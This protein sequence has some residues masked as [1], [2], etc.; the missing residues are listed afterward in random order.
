M[1]FLEKVT[2]CL[3]SCDYTRARI[4]NEHY[5]LTTRLCT[6]TSAERNSYNFDG[7]LEYGGTRSSS[8][9]DAD[10]KLFSFSILGKRTIRLTDTILPLELQQY[11][12][13]VTFVT[14]TYMM[15]L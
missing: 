3:K 8:C 5:V 9:A 15:F 1:S 13:S 7:G 6:W 2:K 11:S 10:Y 12:F 14:V 4:L